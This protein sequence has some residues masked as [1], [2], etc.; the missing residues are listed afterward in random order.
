MLYHHDKRNCFAEA[1]GDRGLDV[2]SYS[3]VL[4]ETSVALD[5]IRKAYKDNSIPMLGLPE[6]ISDIESLKPVVERCRRDFD[7][8]IVLGTGGSSLGGQTLCSLADVGFGPQDGSPR[9]YFI[10]NVDPN[11]FE[12]LFRRINVKRTGFIVISKSGG[13]AETI[14][15]FIVC[16]DAVDQCVGEEKAANHV[17][18]IV[19]PGDNPLRRIANS[20]GLTALD[21]DPGVGGRFSVLS[22]VGLLPAMIS[23]L[24]PVA[25]RAGATRVLKAALEA[26]SPAEC[27]AAIGAAISISLFRDKGATLTVIMPYADRL[28]NFGLWFQQ[29]WAES[30][31]K[32]G[33]GTTPIRALGTRDQHSQMQLYL[34]GPHDKMFTLL[35]L[36]VGNTGRPVCAANT[37]DASL[38]YLNGRSMGDLLSAEQKATLTT[39]VEHGCPIRIFRVKELNEEIL[40]ALLMHFMLE[41][42]IAAHLLGV[43]P[44]DQPAVEEGKRLTRH[45]LSEMDADG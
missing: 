42:I 23:G 15:Q 39:L 22:N 7:T 40:G 9:L 37:S 41:T 44:F 31:G 1:I 21:H 20:R 3:G 10:D 11:T 14:A 26:K 5:A 12:T 38:A 32:D 43:N 2:G 4:K 13:T 16:L 30:L 18:I 35:T 27:E 45:F 8:M 28:S 19:E 33:T 24:D 25:I 36:D 17:L 29:L 6:A 34:D